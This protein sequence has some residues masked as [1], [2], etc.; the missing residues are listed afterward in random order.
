MIKQTLFAVAALCGAIGLTAGPLSAQSTIKIKL[1]SR[2]ASDK[3]TERVEEWKAS[4][5]AIVVCD[6]WDKHWCKHATKRVAELAPSLNTMLNVARGKG[7]KII[8]APSDCTGFYKGHPAYQKSLKYGDGR[9]RWFSTGSVGGEPR[10]PIGDPQPPDGGCSECKWNNKIQWRRQ[11]P[12]IDIKPQDYIVESRGKFSGYINDAGIKNVIVCGVHTNICVLGRPFS[13]RASKS[14]GRRIA[15]IRDM[16][17]LMYN[18]VPGSKKT[19]PNVD[20]WA[21]LNLVVGHIEKYVGPS[22]LSSSI[23]NGNPFRFKE[24]NRPQEKR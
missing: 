17:D 22:I 13:L 1:R 18:N 8:H 24:D 15:L 20:H 11:I 2:D 10:L 16:T 9:A 4:E 19:A 6:M 12:T 21:G 5:T 23:T 14:L 3:I 7:F